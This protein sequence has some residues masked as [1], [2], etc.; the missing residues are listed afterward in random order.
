MASYLP[1]FG[2]HVTSLLRCKVSCLFH[3]RASVRADGL[4]NKLSGLIVELYSGEEQMAA[5]DARTSEEEQT[6]SVLT[7]VRPPVTMCIF[8]PR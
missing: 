2:A 1:N 3:L 7:A 5:L 6:A 8:R 4:E